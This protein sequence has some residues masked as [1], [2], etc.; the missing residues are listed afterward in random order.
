MTTNVFLTLSDF[1]RERW[2]TFNEWI[3]SKSWPMLV[4]IWTDSVRADLWLADH[5]TLSLSLRDTSGC[6]MFLSHSFWPETPLPLMRIIQTYLLC[7]QHKTWFWMR[8]IGLELNI[9]VMKVN[10]HGK[11]Q[12]V[13]S[14]LIV[15]SWVPHYTSRRQLPVFSDDLLPVVIA[16]LGHDVLNQSLDPAHVVREH[17]HD[18]GL[19]HHTLARLPAIVVRYQGDGGVGEP[20]LSGQ[21]DLQSRVN[22][23]NRHF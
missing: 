6:Q 22:S 12:I 14:L 23:L 21:H 20:R 11:C 9:L 18:R 8:I 16:N 15:T 4:G 2:L 19:V 7:D 1:C 17:L 3:L 5:V 10:N 13:I